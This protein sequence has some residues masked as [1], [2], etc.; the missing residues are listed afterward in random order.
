MVFGGEGFAYGIEQNSAEMKLQIDKFNSDSLLWICLKGDC[1]MNK[2][3]VVIAFI[4]VVVLTTGCG[5]NIQ[6]ISS[7]SMRNRNFSN[8]EYHISFDYP[9][10][11][12][13]NKVYAPDRYEGSTGYFQINAISGDGLTIDQV[14][15]SNAN[16]KLNPYGTKPQIDKLA[17]QGQEARL[18]KPSQDQPKEMNNMAL[19]I[20]KYPKASFIGG[21]QYYY[22]EL[23]SD[24]NHIMQIANTIKFLN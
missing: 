9:S 5:V 2:F 4:F 11:W 20:I 22:F 1:I 7:E 13:I 21:E 8:Q 17:I 16:H 24:E 10:T 14:V 3:G 12:K 6:N 15:D 18:I 19:L 23:D